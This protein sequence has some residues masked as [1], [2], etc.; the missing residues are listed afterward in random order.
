MGLRTILPIPRCRNTRLRCRMG[1]RRRFCSLFD[2]RTQSTNCRRTLCTDTRRPTCTRSRPAPSPPARPRGGPAGGRRTRQTSSPPSCARSASPS[3]R[4]RTLEGT[5]TKRL[6]FVVFCPRLNLRFGWVL[7][8]LLRSERNPGNFPGFNG[9]G[10][11]NRR[12]AMAEHAADGKT[13]SPTGLLRSAR[14]LH[15]NIPT[16]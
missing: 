6:L 14:D 1:P 3:P 2:S 10:G 4:P 9:Q 13:R 5:Q 11:P 15:F 12:A 8:Q 7:D 16:F